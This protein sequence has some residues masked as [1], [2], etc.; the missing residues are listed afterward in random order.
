MHNLREKKAN[1]G[2]ESHALFDKDDLKGT[3]V[4]GVVFNENIDNGLLVS[5]FTEPLLHLQQKGYQTTV[6]SFCKPWA[7]PKEKRINVKRIPIALPAKLFMFNSLSFIF[8]T[9]FAFF[10]SLI[11]SFYLRKNRVYIVR[12]YFPSYILAT[13]KLFL[14]SVEFV[15]DPRSL[16]I[17]ENVGIGNIKGSGI[18]YQVWRKIEKFI[19]KQSNKTITVSEKQEEH[20]LSILPSAKIIRIPCYARVADFSETIGTRLC[21]DFKIPIEKILICYFG[22]INSGWNNVNLYRQFLAANKSNNQCHFVFISQN[23]AELLKIN[24]FNQENIT[25]IP[26]VVPAEH[27]KQLMSACDYGLFLMARNPD[28]ETRLGVKFAEYC[29]QGVPVLLS[30]YIGEAVKYVKQYE[31]LSH[32]SRILDSTFCLPEVSKAPSR[33]KRMI[34]DL[35]KKLFSYANVERIF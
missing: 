22:S 34:Q 1:G 24:D 6:I 18:N 13:V 2:A 32:R 5:Q 25:L 10:Y 26:D 16:F 8:V 30:P 12:S 3:T 17:D 14:P 4:V 15:F 23:Y 28:W 35:A 29:A 11:F 19:L 33:E 9:L 27:K 7:L 21:N 20:Y 31:V